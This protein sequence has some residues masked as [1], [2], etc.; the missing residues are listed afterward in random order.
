LPLDC[1][2]WKQ[3]AAAVWFCLPLLT[4]PFQ[5]ILKHIRCNVSGSNCFLLCRQS[6]GSV[7][8]NHS[9]YLMPHV[10]H[11]LETGCNTSVPSAQSHQCL[12]CA[13]V[14]YAAAMWHRACALQLQPAGK[15]ILNDGQHLEIAQQKQMPQ[16]V[17]NLCLVV[18]INGQE[19]VQTAFIIKVTVP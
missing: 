8:Y 18:Q 10:F 15:Q 19:M 12:A 2:L 9:K 16:H 5:C 3:A 13:H 7:T 6:S 1:L 17:R 14:V 4:V 11:A